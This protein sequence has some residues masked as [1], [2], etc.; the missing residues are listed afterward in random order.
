[1]LEN[2]S[3]PLSILRYE[4]NKANRQEF[5]AKEGFLR[6]RRDLTKLIGV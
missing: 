3:D 6:T 1:M 4:L 5:K 2:L